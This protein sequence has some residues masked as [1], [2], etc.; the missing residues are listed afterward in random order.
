MNEGEFARQIDG[1]KKVELFSR[2]R[3]GDVPSRDLLRKSPSGKG[4]GITL[5][6]SA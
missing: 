4:Y 5:L 2:L 6:V 3:F 1:D